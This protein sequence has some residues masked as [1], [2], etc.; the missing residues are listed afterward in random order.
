MISVSLRDCKAWQNVKLP[1]SSPSDEACKMYDAVLTQYISWQNDKSLG[2]IEKC[3]ARLHA[4]DPN[5]VM[6]HVIANGLEV[7][8]TGRSILLDNELNSAIKSTVELARNQPLT[9]RERLHVSALDCFARGCLPKACDLW[10]KIL[11]DHPTDM[12]ALKFAHDSYFYLGYQQQMR[13]SIARVLPHWTPQIPLYGYLKGMYSFGL[14]E[15]NFYD[16][17]EKVAKEG[18]RLNPGD[19]WSVHS[20]AHVYEMKAEASNG[21]QFMTQTE[22]DWQGSDL[23]VCHIYWHWALY[24]I[25]KGEYE[26]ALTLFDDHI[27]PRCFSSG[28]MLDIVDACSMLYRLQME[29]VK[30]G[31]R[32]NKLIPVTKPHAK[33]HILVF[34]DLHILM[35]SLGSKDSETTNQFLSSLQELISEPGENYQ[36]SLGQK[37][38]LP[39]CQALVE[40]ENGNYE[41]TVE[42]LHPLRYQI[43]QIGGSDAQ[44]DLFNLL[45]IHA[46]LKSESSSHRKL[47]RCLLTERDACRPNSSMTE[48]LIRQAAAI[49]SVD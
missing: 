29:G 36:H 13:D 11:L 38:G 28:T 33:D 15:T 31:D 22:K 25:E 47:G 6:G 18:L 26:A 40:F 35:S 8:G 34:N 12:L 7:I 37:L 46:A 2:G 30:V 42:I 5:F 45:L 32:W 4:A 10:E 19:T 17:A 49:H 39:L 21:L 20:V 44:R 14:V 9:E 24:F 16:Q 43:V 41:K 1:L 27:S 3:L 23:L 48:R